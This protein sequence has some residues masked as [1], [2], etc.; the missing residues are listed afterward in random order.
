VDI[1]ERKRALDKGAADRAWAR[2]CE[3]IDRGEPVIVFGADPKADPKASPFVATGYS[4]T[5]DT[6]FGLPHATWVPAPKWDGDGIAAQGYVARPRPDETNWIGSGFAPGQGMGGA[7]LSF[8]ALQDRTH[9]PSQREIARTVLERALGLTRGAL[10]DELRSWRRSGA[11]ALEHLSACLAQ[12]G[13]VYQDGDWQASWREVGSRDDFWYAMEGLAWPP[14]RKT[15]AAFFR[16]C[17]EGFGGLGATARALLHEAHAAALESVAAFERYWAL[18]AEAGPLESYEDHGETVS[19][20]FGDRGS[21]KTASERA[22]DMAAA[23]RRVADKLAAAIE[24]ET[25]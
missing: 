6:V 13:D 2:V 8:F 16:H 25:R 21:R 20:I 15:G 5:R 3:H 4:T 12:D 22:A 14:F 1:F 17:A 23:E 10:F 19:K 7:A 11:V 9:C 18:F 24:S